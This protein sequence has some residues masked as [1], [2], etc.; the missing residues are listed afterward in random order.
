GL[1]V[2]GIGLFAS[3]LGCTEP[4]EATFSLL[5][6]GSPLVG[7]VLGL[8]MLLVVTWCWRARLRLLDNL[9]FGAL[10]GARFFA[11]HRTPVARLL[12]EEAHSEIGELEHRLLKVLRSPWGA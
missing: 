3:S 12:G 1:A 8:G 6:G 7:G 11:N 9:C 10:P 2:S 4:R 5:S